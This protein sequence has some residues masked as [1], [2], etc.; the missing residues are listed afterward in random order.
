[1]GVGEVTQPEP[2]TYEGNHE[3]S[4]GGWAILGS[5]Q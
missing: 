2:E 3:S 4:V 5:N 1:M